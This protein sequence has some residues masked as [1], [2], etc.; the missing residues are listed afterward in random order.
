[1]STDQDPPTAAPSATSS[2]PDQ[3]IEMTNA[4]PLPPPPLEAQSQAPPAS[5]PAAAA[6]TSDSAIPS[7]DQAAPEPEKEAEKIIPGPRA[8]YLQNLFTQAAKHTLDKLSS[9]ANFASCFPTISAKAPGTLDNVQRQMVDRLGGLWN[10]EFERILEARDVVRKLN[11]LEVLLGDAGRR[12]EVEGGNSVRIPPHTLPVETVLKGHLREGMQELKQRLEGRL[13]EIQEGNL[14]LFEEIKQQRE[15]MEGML[16]GVER[17]VRD[18]EG[19]N[20][21]LA[22]EEEGKGELVEEVVEETRGT[23]A[24]IERVLKGRE[25]V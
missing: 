18:L 21:V 17:V 10:R 5:G 25:R 3:D 13:K 2:G 24:D 23:E 7:S 14:K 16:K 1:M 9:P 11:E 12:R 8:T 4:A 15:E 20:R 22:G 6:Q 19:A